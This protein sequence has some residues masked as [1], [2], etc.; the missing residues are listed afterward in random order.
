VQQTE[1]DPARFSD[2][3]PQAS[4]KSYGKAVALSAALGFSGVHLFYLGRVGEGLLDVGLTLGWLFCFATDRPG[5][6]VLLLLADVGHALVVTILLL[7][8]SF[9]DGEGRLVC[10]PGQKLGGATTLNQPMRRRS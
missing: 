6:G 10:Y 4:A 3:V 1:H 2:P 5:L 8:G 9:R 7:T